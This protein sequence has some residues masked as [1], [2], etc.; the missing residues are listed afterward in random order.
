[1]NT[2][3]ALCVD[4]QEKILQISGP[5]EEPSETTTTTKESQITHEHERNKLSKTF[6]FTNALFIS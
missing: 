1:M 5:T 6:T 2:V 4:T 3:Q